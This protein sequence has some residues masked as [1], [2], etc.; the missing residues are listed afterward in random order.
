MIQSIRYELLSF[1]LLHKTIT[2][3][4]DIYLAL[5]NYCYYIKTTSS[6]IIKL[7][8]LINTNVRFIYHI[9]KNLKIL[10]IY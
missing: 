2:N 4:I 8:I 9:D 1:R 10:H 7:K 3:F 5:F 6:H